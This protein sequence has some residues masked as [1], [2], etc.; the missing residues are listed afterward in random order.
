MIIR[1]AVVCLCLIFISAC[2]D[3]KNPLAP[4]LCGI[5]E[6]GSVGETSNVYCGDVNITN[7]VN[8]NDND[9]DNEPDESEEEITIT[10]SHTNDEG[11]LIYSI[12]PGITF[13]RVGG[14][15]LSVWCRIGSDC[16]GTNRTES[17]VSSPPSNWI[18]YK[19]AEFRQSGSLGNNVL[20]NVDGKSINHLF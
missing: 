15:S 8:D 12:G 16:N 5:F 4:D 19:R 9:D 7:P 6:G 2:G 1:L 3:D 13:K 11:R 18:S 17:A 10:I 14:S 20:F